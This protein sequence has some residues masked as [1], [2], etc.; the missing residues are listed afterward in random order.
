[1]STIDAESTEALLDGRYRLGPCVGRGGTSVVYRAEDLVLG[2]T[3]AIKLLRSAEDVPAGAERAQS[4]TAL[5]A[6]LN[7]PSLITL[8]DARLDPTHPRYLAMEYVDGPTLATRL[9][10][11]PLSRGEAASL[12]CDLA[13]ALQA[14]HD[15][16][17]I[18]RDV[19]PSNVLLAPLP[20]D[21]GWTAKLTDFGIAYGPDD[22]R[23]T[24]PG[25]AVGTAAYMAPEQVR[26]AALTPAVD[27]YSL[28]LV[29]LESLTGEPAFPTSGS[30]Q[31]ALRRLTEAP[32]IP[33]SIGSGWGSL[34]AWMTRID[35]SD[36]PA[37]RDVA[38]AAALLGDDPS[39]PAGSAPP[40]AGALPVEA[41]PPNAAGST[42]EYTAESAPAAVP[43]SERRRPARFRA[44]VLGVI[45]AVV[46]CGAA[47]SGLW[48]SGQ[49][50][51]SPPREASL[52]TPTPQPSPVPGNGTQEPS[53][54]TVVSSDSG[55][56]P[57]GPG[58][59]AQNGGQGQKAGKGPG[60]DRDA[61][62]PPQ[63]GKN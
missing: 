26:S 18:H 48:A 55:T 61:G 41:G 46:V 2:R 47:L 9:T 36:R 60:K 42:R 7:H 52:T 45:A 51:P 21:G 3:V 11:G 33:E 12:A 34:V 63:N 38:C 23:R 22:A 62:H 5:L 50:V 58:Q 24:S 43:S 49:S 30:V 19:K 37:A 57:G 16:G 13:G 17:I 31:T 8:Y 27:V 44:G 14:V 1:M 29:L 39:D 20:N 10:H 15:A 54:G 32:E 56:Q 4:E 25:I 35:P 6:T 28:G 59:K 40:G 53:G